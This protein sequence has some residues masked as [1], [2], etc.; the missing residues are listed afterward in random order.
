MHLFPFLNDKGASF[1]SDSLREENASPTS[2]SKKDEKKSILKFR[3]NDYRER[4]ILEGISRFPF[5]MIL[6]FFTTFL[7]IVYLFSF[8]FA[9]HDLATLAD[10]KTKTPALFMDADYLN[11]GSDNKFDLPIEKESTFFFF[12]TLANSATEFK[13][14]SNEIPQEDLQSQRYIANKQSLDNLLE[15]VKKT[16][17]A[18][19]K[20]FIEIVGRT[21]DTPI[22]KQDPNT[23][24]TFASNYDLSLAR[25]QNLRFDLLRRLENYPGVIEKIEWS[26][27]PGSN[28]SSLIRDFPLNHPSAR[29]SLALIESPG[30]E[31]TENNDLNPEEQKRVINNVAEQL[32]KEEYPKVKDLALEDQLSSKRSSLEKHINSALKL[33]EKPATFPNKKSMQKLAS[34]LDEEFKAYKTIKDEPGDSELDKKLYQDKANEFDHINQKINAALVFYASEEDKGNRRITEVYITSVPYTTSSN[35]LNIMDYILYSITNTGYGDVKPTTLYAK[36][37]SVL[38]NIVSIFFLVVFF[39]ALLSVKRVGEE[40]DLFN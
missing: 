17:P 20:I 40:D 23:K 13:N 24:Q 10:S 19:K 32:R 35:P 39:N 6:F 7:C 34:S 9:F 38:I 31:N 25:A 14:I 1:D 30:I 22:N 4:K 33:L 37:L 36:F 27:L 2:L 18:A 11:P 8:S 5:H 3:L 15:V 16:A 28:D 29:P 21:D 26:C 12:Y